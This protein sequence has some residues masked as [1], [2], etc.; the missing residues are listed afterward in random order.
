VGG[1][2][3]EFD[4]PYTSKNFPFHDECYR[5]PKVG[6]SWGD[7]DV[8]LHVHCI[9]NMKKREFMLLG[10][11]DTLPE[12]QISAVI[13][14]AT[15]SDAEVIMFRGVGFDDDI[16][17]KLM[18]SMEPLDPENNPE[19]KS[20]YV[21]APWPTRFQKKVLRE[22][23]DMCRHGDFHE[24][25]LAYRLKAPIEEVHQHLE[26]LADLGLMEAAG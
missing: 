25:S 15:L 9:R 1:I 5:W 18:A 19:Y 26:L 23:Y 22:A 21:E 14:M 24:T 12:D 16:I 2:M 20:A 7:D 4:F 10:F 6:V 13:Y 11:L 8:V 17:T 3:S